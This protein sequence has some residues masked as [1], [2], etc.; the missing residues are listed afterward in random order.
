[1]LIFDCDGVLVDS[2]LIACSLLA[3]KITLLG[4]PIS[5][6]ETMMRFLGRSLKD[7]TI[8]IEELIGR[9]FGQ[10]EGKADA[11]RLMEQFARELQPVR[12]VRNAILA[13]P[14]SRCVASSSSPDRLRNS[15]QITGLLDLFDPHVFSATQV[16]QGKPA[17]DLFLL[18]AK[19]CG[20]QPQHCIVV[21]DSPAGVTAAMA[22]GMRAVGFIG[23]SHATP[24]LGERLHAAGAAV[25][26]NDMRFLPEVVAGLA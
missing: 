13:L 17:P 6:A 7:A 2:E 11:Q 5:L 4:R 8:E 21:E 16:A 3:E 19:T 22:A 9:K 26:I 18:A 1:M 12:G 24:E 20:A 15:L 23:A 25:V 10:D 14:G